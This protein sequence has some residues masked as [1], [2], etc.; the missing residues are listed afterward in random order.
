[1]REPGNRGIGGLGA[2]A[3]GEPLGSPREGSAEGAQRAVGRANRLPALVGS[4]ERPHW[5]EGLGGRA[6]GGLEG[7]VTE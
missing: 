1:M 7:P 3:E 2:G 6:E 5:G 4:H